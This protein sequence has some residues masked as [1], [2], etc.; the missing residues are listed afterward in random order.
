MGGLDRLRDGGMTRLLAYLTML[1]L[2]AWALLEILGGRS[3]ERI[4][5]WLVAAVVIHDLVALPLYSAADRAAQTALRGA[6]NYVRIPVALSLLML[7]VFWATIAE[8][9]EGAY[10]ATS[11]ETFEGHATRWLLVSA[12]LF[13]ASGLLYLLRRGSRS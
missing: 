13:A 2:C 1:P 12:A 7:L 10:R 9:G 11:G 3:A 8:K 4:A 5:M 6:V